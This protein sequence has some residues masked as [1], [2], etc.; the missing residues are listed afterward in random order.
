MVT[1][2]KAKPRKKAATEQPQEVTTPAS[3][4]PGPMPMPM[5]R[6]GRRPLYGEAKFDLVEPLEGEEPLIVTIQINL[7]YE[8]LEAIPFHEGATNLEAWQAIAP[9]VT[10]WNVKRWNHATGE[11]EPVPPPAEAGWEVLKVLDALETYWLQ[12]VV[13]FGYKRTPQ[14]EEDRGNASAGSLTTPTSENAG[15]STDPAMKTTKPD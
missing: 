12:R 1:K 4:T 2:T 14:G 6:V 9:F 11:K 8:Q 13:R 5:A 3:E 7:A 10:A 15:D